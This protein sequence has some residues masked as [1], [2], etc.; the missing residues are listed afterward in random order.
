[1]LVMEDLS[2]LELGDQV[3]GLSLEQTAAGL[4]GL[5]KHH[6]LFGTVQAWSAPSSSR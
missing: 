6:V 4:S 1:M 2:D 5:A 3:A